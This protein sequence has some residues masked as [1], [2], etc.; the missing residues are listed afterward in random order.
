MKRNPV[1]LNY[2]RSRA[3]CATQAGL[4]I[5]LLDLLVGDLRRAVGALQAG[6]V[7]A[8]SHEIKHAFLVLQQLEGSLDIANGGEA[9][10]HFSQFYSFLRGKILEAQIKMS[11]EI[12]NEQIEL[13]L[14]VR[15]AWQELD[16]PAIQE[17]AKSLG[18]PGNGA[19]T[20]RARSATASA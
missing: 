11:Q 12:L 13:I 9:A 8:R 19:N 17:Q 20:Q 15:N 16:S 6:N 2:L 10:R 1:E 14:G 7:E 3:E 18:E 5:L 4:V